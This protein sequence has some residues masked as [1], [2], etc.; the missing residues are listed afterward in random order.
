MHL[1]S[2]PFSFLRRSLGIHD[3]FSM[4]L[5]ASEKHNSPQSVLRWFIYNIKRVV[6]QTR[7]STTVFG[8]VVQTGPF[9][10]RGCGKPPL[11]PSHL[12]RGAPAS[13]TTE[14]EVKIVW[15]Q[16]N[17]S[18]TFGAMSIVTGTVC[19]TSVRKGMTDKNVFV[20]SIW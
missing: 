7:I 5:S 14:T 8:S 1:L 16:W 4:K 18:T 3:L 6:L 10:I 9:K 17:I 20:Y 19:S 11:P 12:P 2:F 13:P 15:R